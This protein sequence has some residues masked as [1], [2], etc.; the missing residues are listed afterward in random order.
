MSA[1]L[2]YFQCFPSDFL[3]GLSGLSPEEQVVYFTIVLRNYDLGGPVLLR[4]YERDLCQRADVTKRKLSLIARTNAILSSTM[5]ICAMDFR[6]AP[7]LRACHGFAA[8]RR[9]LSQTAAWV[10][11]L[12][13]L[14]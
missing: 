12:L 11:Y 13:I 8:R 14:P 7:H 4:H 5:R 10:H 1:G 9:V 3:A 6:L 2:P